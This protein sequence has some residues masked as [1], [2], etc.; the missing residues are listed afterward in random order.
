MKHSKRI[1]LAALAT[2]ALTAL[3]AAPSASATTLAVGGVAQNRS[4]TIHLTLR[5]GTS[6]L[7]TD[8]FRN[9]VSTCTESTWHAVT[10]TPFTSTGTNSIGGRVGSLS[11]SNCNPGA[12]VVHRAGTLSVQARTSDNG[13]GTVFSS[14]AEWTTPSPFG[15]LTCTTNNTDLGTLTGVNSGN[16]TLDVNAVVTCSG[17]GT[18]KVNG[19][20]TVTVPAG[21]DV[22]A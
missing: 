22:T 9:E 4:V 3:A 7:L 16:A 8:T 18:E 1:A 10:E 21:L 5:T 14:G 19:T 12:E 6:L 20:Y 2:M 13:N 11:T 15:T 17:I